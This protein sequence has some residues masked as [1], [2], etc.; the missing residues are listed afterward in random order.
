MKG[1]RMSLL[2]ST[3]FCGLAGQLS[4]QHGAGRPAAMSKAFHARCAG[5]PDAAALLAAL[6]EDERDEVL[7]W[8]APADIDY[9]SGVVRYAEM[10]KELEVCLDR[11]GFAC[12]ASDPD[13]LTVGHLD[14][15]TVIEL[16]DFGRVAYV[17]DIKKTVW[18]AGEGPESLQLHAYAQAYAQL[19]DCK[20]YTTGLWIGETGEWLWTG[21][22]VLLGSPRAVGI[23]DRVLRAAQ[24]HGEASSGPHCQSCWSRLHCPEYALPL[25]T[26][27]QWQL[28]L[29]A[30]EALPPEEQ[31][32][33][34]F[35]LQA[36]EAL[37]TKIRKEV[38][39]RVRRGR[40]APAKDGSRY[41]P[42][43]MPGRESVSVKALREGLGEGAEAFIT[44]GQPYDQ[45]RWLKERA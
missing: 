2:G 1:W 25:Q 13:C 3:Q 12:E 31:A 4:A 24:N 38:Q 30:F 15:A 17:G 43:I 44:R 5:M 21:S 29:E 8:K 28:S 11:F 26:F 7:E 45:F 20:A 23:L 10:E 36:T 33:F 9:G 35:K 18:T 41:L 27:D 6:T 40:A 16:P 37:A 14:M 22:M 39:E 19:R 42:V 32:Q 34:L